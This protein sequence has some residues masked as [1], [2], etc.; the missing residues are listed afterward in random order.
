MHLKRLT[1]HGFKSFADKTDFEFESLLTGIVGP[2]GCGK[3]NVVDALKWV[4]GDQ[5]AKSLRGKEMTDVIFKGA[6]GR[7]G[8]HQA[9]VSVTLT[10]AEGIYG[11]RTEIT[12]GRRLTKDKESEYLLNG[13][14]VRLKDVRDVLM[15]TGLGVGAYSVMEQGRIDAVLSA[16]AEDR[17][18]IF[19]EAA[20]ISRFKLQKR[21]TLRK[22][23]RTEINLERVKDLLEERARRIRSLKI[24]AGKA[25]RF[26]ELRARLRD[27]RAATAVVEARKLRLERRQQD[28]R[29]TELTE[30]VTAAEARCAE[31]EAG[32]DRLDA[33]IDA[34]SREHEALQDEIRQVQS[35]REA[36][37][38]QAE[39]HDHRAGDQRDHAAESRRRHDEL[40]EQDKEKTAALAASMDRVDKLEAELVELAGEGEVRQ[41]A[42]ADAQAVV[43]ELHET[44]ERVR[45]RVLELMNERTRAQN[46]A[47]DIR[48]QLKAQD[49][50]RAGLEQ[51]H[52]DQDSEITAIETRVAAHQ[53]ELGR[54]REEAAQL[55]IEERM[56]LEELHSADTEVAELARR[57]SELRQ[58]LSSISGRLHVLADLETHMEGLDHGPRYLLQEKPEGLRGRLIDLFDTD[59]EFSA[60]LE[61]ALGQFVQALVVRSR[62]DAHAMHALLREKGK[63]RAIL[64]IE[65]EIGEQLQADRPIFGWPEGTS[66]LVEHIRFPES[67]KHLVHWL[68]RGAC[69]IESLDNAPPNRPDLCFVTRGG[70]LLCGPRIEGGSEEGSSGLVVRKAT[71]QALTAEE[72][73]VR[74]DLDAL[75]AGKDVV[76]ARVA[77]HK[78]EVRAL[79]A[80][81]QEIRSRI[82]GKEAQREDL[83]S[84]IVQGERDIDHLR[85]M[86]KELDAQRSAARA[87]MTTKFLGAF[88]IGRQED[89]ESRRESEVA[90][91]LSNAQGRAEVVA[92]EEQTVQLRLVAIRS[93]REA[94]R[95]ACRIHEQTLRE[96]SATVKVLAEREEESEQAAEEYAEKA[97][98]C[99]EAAAAT[100][101]E[102]SRLNEKRDHAAHA[103]AA[104]RK[105][106]TASKEDLGEQQSS[107]SDLAEQ[108]N[109]VRLRLGEN[110]HAFQWLEKRL[111]DDVGV[112]L[113]RCLGEIEG[114]GFTVGDIVG[115]IPG[116]DD[117]QPELLLGPPIP[118]TMLVDESALHRLWENED[119]DVAACSQEMEVLQAKVERLG[120]VNLD[121][122]DELEEE[123]SEI[124]LTEREVQD[125]SEAR[126]SL[127][128]ALRR[129]EEESRTMFEETFNKARENFQT[130]FR[131]LFQG[132]RADMFLTDGE[133]SLEGGIEIVARPP[134]KELQSINLLS[135]GERTL[136]ALAILFGVFKVKPSPFC[137]LDEVDAALDDTNVER[138]LRVLNDFVGPSQFCIVTHHKRTMAACNMLYGITMQKRGVSSRIAVNLEQIDELTQT[139]LHDDAKG[140]DSMA[141]KQRIAGE[142]ALGF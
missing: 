103:L 104:T 89:R 25:R 77:E 2:N 5:R 123:E 33:Q 99:R 57:E 87:S 65:E 56:S 75:L 88:C 121:A 122:V 35:R 127:V 85:L 39:T 132:G 95:D 42:V 135:G 8:S 79:G 19:E 64:L 66:S 48:A 62:S 105:E 70:G 22:L 13:S 61:A 120:S 32:R 78:E 28:D 114:M 18:A 126:T 130:I 137:I 113:R 58:A 53:V 108:I 26:R 109:G 9:M 16:N 71:M 107:K 142:E 83:L 138:F 29:I 101:G 36:A 84:R 115:P 119:F 116:E 11:D 134:G 93:D 96:L 59:V 106:Y 10:D 17:R 45:Q 31:L 54:C 133:D 98:E 139:G 12:I 14:V 80:M 81:L 68:L 52:D 55:V 73:V 100:E 47:Q 15:N 23:D 91:E 40:I 141:E 3:S 131:K 128:E 92:R 38:H 34:C 20:G 118:E 51:R 86:I 46:A 63:G 49:A 125:L 90:A 136:T 6:E 24:Q 27:F 60:G 94:A 112:A 129:M 50:R 117:P 97:V 69:V 124:V 72:K 44:R 41:K 102:L 37:E 30:A 7:D 82:H 140:Q 74:R 110:E 4:L 43:R 67:A 1:V 111:F 76:E 21:E